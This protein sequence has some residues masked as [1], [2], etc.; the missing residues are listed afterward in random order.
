[1]AKTKTTVRR[2]AAKKAS[3]YAEPRIVQSWIAP[4]R[5]YVS[6][7]A[8]AAFDDGLRGAG[9]VEAVSSIVP[10]WRSLFETA[11]TDTALISR[12]HNSRC[13]PTSETEAPEAN[14]HK[15]AIWPIAKRDYKAGKRS[16]MLDV[17]RAA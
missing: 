4:M 7:L 14:V 15:K 3:R 5:A 13:G 16:F 9:L 6:C 8:T 11:P 1:M 2:K 12:A 17:K 10:K